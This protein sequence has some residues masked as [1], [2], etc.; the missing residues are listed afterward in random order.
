MQGGYIIQVADLLQK[1]WKGDSITIEKVL[2]DDAL[3]LTDEWVSCLLQLQSVNDTA[4]LA[5]FTDI[6]AKIKRKSDFSD[7][8]FT[9]NIFVE[10]YQVRFV[11]DFDHNNDHAYDDV[12]PIDHK[13]LTIDISLP[14]YHALFVE[15]PIVNI[16]PEEEEMYKKYMMNSSDVSDDEFMA[17]WNITFS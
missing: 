12:F 17:G 2:L 5:T 8:I 7:E 11:L 3:W 10:K 1:V 14:L 13:W 16:A 4:V 6:K 9:D 15:E